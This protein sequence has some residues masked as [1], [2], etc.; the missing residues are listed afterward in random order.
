[1]LGYRTVDGMKFAN[2]LALRW[3]EEPGLSRW[4]QCSHK[5]SMN[6]IDTD[7]RIRRIEERFENG[8]L[9]ALTMKGGVMS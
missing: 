9:L 8:A 1:M 5:G 7:R 3:E 6:K 2:Q 4:N